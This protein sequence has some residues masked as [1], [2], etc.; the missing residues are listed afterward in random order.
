MSVINWPL[1]RR[2]FGILLMLETIFLALSSIVSAFYSAKD[3][4]QD[5][6]ALAIATVACG[7]CGSILVLS[8]RSFKESFSTR[9]GFLVVSVT[10]LLFTFFGMLPYL[11]YGTCHTWADAFL[12][13]ISGFTTTGCTVLNDIDSQPHG[14]LFWR[15]LTQWIGG[16]GIVVFTLALLPRI[17]NGNIQMFSAEVTGMQ[18]DKLRPTI[19]ATSRR[20]WFIYISLTLVC[21]F[22][23]TLGGMSLFDA[24]CHS[25]TT[26]SSGG[27]S[28][29][30]SSIGFFHSSY[31]EYVCAIFMFITSINFSLF[32]LIQRGNYKRFWQ[33]QELRSFFRIVLF[34]TALF[35]I[36]HLI[37]D[38]KT[39]L[40][41]EQI[42]AMPH[43]IADTIRSS[44]F[45][46]VTIM[47][48]SGF[49]AESY[50][51]NLWGM[52]FWLPTIA[53]MA[54]GGCAG[55]TA[56]GL[57][58]LRV[59]ILFKNIAQEAIHHLQPNSYTSIRLNGNTLNTEHAHRTMAFMFLFILIGIVSVFVLQL[60][61]FDTDTAIGTT[62]T[63]LSNTGPGLG[64]TGPAF[65]WAALPAF[66]KVFLGV[67]MLVGRLEIFTVILLFYPRFWKN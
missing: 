53:I 5:F 1:V 22:L 41:T 17:P 46:V 37:N 55:S 3:G 62:V 60:Q 58:V 13:T 25:L 61:G 50:D 30:Q 19:Q 39:G 51:Y 18:V 6:A 15:S 16:L 36:L 63:A 10:W 52:P 8:A 66:S 29:H 48:T 11:I 45:H 9:E 65:T 26:M 28:T 47:S 24:I 35:T 12:E 54:C 49:Q 67:I 57:K 23:Y 34:F 59:V 20:L 31:I 21:A 27:F 33:D 32:Y 40:S 42:E 38:T 43:G 2:I 56:G 44:F 14:I 64:A 4:E 7:I